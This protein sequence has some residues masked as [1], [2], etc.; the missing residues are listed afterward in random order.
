MRI[1]K[2][3]QQPVQVV[4]SS[5]VQSRNPE[6][7]GIWIGPHGDPFEVF[8]LGGLERLGD[9]FHSWPPTLEHQFFEFHGGR[10]VNRTLRGHV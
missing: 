8:G 9:P 2:L 6:L 10:Q 1:P 4:P 5:A 7:E 3:D